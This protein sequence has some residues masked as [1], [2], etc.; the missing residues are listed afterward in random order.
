M[1]LCFFVNANFNYRI[2]ELL[3][4]EAINELLEKYNNCVEVNPEDVTYK[5]LYDIDTDK[6]YVEFTIR[7]T[8]GDNSTNE[9][10]EAYDTVKFEI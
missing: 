8:I 5:Y 10:A 6:K 7:N 2:I 1:S 9:V 4:N 3:K